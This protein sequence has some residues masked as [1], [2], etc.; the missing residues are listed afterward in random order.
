MCSRCATSCTAPLVAVAPCSATLDL[1]C[2][3]GSAPSKSSS[4]EPA[5]QAPAGAASTSTTASALCSAGS[6]FDATMSKCTLCT[7]GCD[8][9]EELVG[10]CGGDTGRSNAQC[11]PCL[12][13]FYKDAGMNHASPCASCGDV[14]PPACGCVCYVCSILPVLFARRFSLYFAQSHDS[15]PPFH[16]SYTSY[17]GAIGLT[18]V[19]EIDAPNHRGSSVLPPSEE[20]FSTS[21]SAI[22]WAALIVLVCGVLVCITYRCG[23][24][25]KRNPCLS[26]VLSLLGRLSGVVGS[27]V[28]VGSSNSSRASSGSQYSPTGRRGQRG[29]GGLQMTGMGGGTASKGAN[30]FAAAKQQQVETHARLAEWQQHSRE[31]Y[32]TP[33]EKNRVDVYHDANPFA[34]TPDPATPRRLDLEGARGGGGDGG[35]GRKSQS[36]RSSRRK[37]RSGSGRRRGNRS[38]ARSRSPS[39]T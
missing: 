29:G 39:P 26:C 14:R 8:V 12:T 17:S 9:G 22:A 13:G 2:S 27:L 34:R 32:L 25:K 31:L 11:M 7:V 1:Q 37:K 21:V 33:V 23:G 24:C 20:T 38:V 18:P 4:A 15:L 6:W 19:L 36:R 10:V 3:S 16:V 35:S 5:A 28:G 30:A